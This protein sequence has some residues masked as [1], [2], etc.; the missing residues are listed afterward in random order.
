MPNSNPSTS[1]PKKQRLLNPP[2][3]SKTAYLDVQRHW[4]KLGPIF[5]SPRA[6]CIWMPCLLE[7]SMQRAFDHGFKYS[8]PRSEPYCPA[9][10]DSCDWRFNREKRGRMPE[11]WDYVCHSACHWIVDLDLFV[12]INAYP[13][14]PWRIVSHQKHSTVWNGD[15]GKPVLF[16]VNFLALGVPAAEA[17]WTAWP[18]RLLKPWE[19]LKPYLHPHVGYGPRGAAIPSL[20]KPIFSSALHKTGAVCSTNE[21]PPSDPPAC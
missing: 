15:L 10:F 18:G 19:Y 7:Y 16:D 13:K 6:A 9:M 2:D 21:T 8:P 14:I 1:S 17:L 20:P 4:G 11:Y 3:Y 5:R 12:A